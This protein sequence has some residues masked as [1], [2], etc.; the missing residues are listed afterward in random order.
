MKKSYEELYELY[1]KSKDP[2]E[3]S[4]IKQ[5]VDD[6]SLTETDE[7]FQS[8]PGHYTENFNDLIYQKKEFNANQLFLDTRG[9]E[10]A[11]GPDFSIKAHQSFLKNFMTK[12]SPYK[13]L[14]IYHG[15]GVGKTCSGLTI[16]ENF[17][18]TYARKDRRIL[19]LS[20]KNIQLGWKKTIYTPD[21]GE[22]QCTGDT[23][24]NSDATTDRGVNKL[25]KRYYE[26]MAYQSFSN[27][28]DKMIVQYTQRLP[29]D[30]K[31]MGEEQCIRE[32]FSNRLM[33]IDE[34]H[35]IRDE[36]GSTMR[37]TVKTIEKV[38]QY[39]DNLRLVLLTATPMYNRA[40]EILWILNMMLLND[41]R[42]II[43]NK[44]V[45]NSN[46]ELSEQ[47]SI[48]L[49]EKSRGYVSYLRGENPI[50]FPIR[51]Y[52]RQ[53]KDARRN[54]Y[55]PNYSKDKQNSIINR[56]FAPLVN[57]VGGKIKD[58]LQFLELFGSKLGGLQ[59]LVYKQAIKNLVDKDPLLDIDVR[60]EMNPILD[61]VSLTQITDMTYPSEKDNLVKK[62]ND[63]DINVDEFYGER[64]LKN[65]M[66]KRGSNYTY[67][68]KILDKYGPIFDKDN[69][70]DYSSKLSSIINIIDETEGIIFI[71]TNYVSAGIVPLQL[72]LEQNGYKKHSG[73]TSLQ[74]PGWSKSAAKGKTKREPISFDGLRRS[75]VDDRFQQASYM[76]I[77]ASTNK[78]T[79]Q[80]QLKIIN[81][82]ENKNGEKIKVIIGTV[83][84]SE[85][86]DFKRI[87]CVHILDPWHHL[88][89]TEQTIG[90]S[91]RFCSHS[92]LSDNKK[93]VLI[94]LHT[95]TLPDGMESIDT[96]IYRY[97]ERKSFQIGQVEMI[98]KRCAVD[99]YLYK[100]VNVIGKGTIQHIS[101]S[102]PLYNAIDVRVDP[103]DTSYSKVCSYSLDCDYNKGLK[104]EEDPLLNDDTFLD[105]YSSTS[106]SN[107][108][109]K[110]ALLF[111]EFYVYDINSILGLLN[112]YGFNQDT[113]I[114]QALDKMI[115]HKYVIHDKIGSSGYI[116]NS[117]KYYIFQPF[118]LEDQ[119]IPMYYR[120]NSITLPER[121]ITLPRLNEVDDTCNCSKT[122]PLD[123]I[124]EVY[125]SLWRHPDLVNV[126]E[127][128]NIVYETSSMNRV[129]V[130]Y[131]FDRLDFKDKCKLMYGYFRK[132]YEFKQYPIYDEVESLVD[133][134]IV[135][136]SKSKNDYYFNNEPID[137]K[138]TD[139]FGFVLSYN[140][141]PC[142]YEYYQGELIRC[143][144]VQLNQLGKSLDR[145]TKSPHYKQFMKS[146]PTWGY[147]IMRKKNYKQE[148]V[149]KFVHP[150]TKGAPE[151]T[152]YPPGPGNVCIEN[153]RASSIKDLKAVLE[154]DYGEVLQK[155]NDMQPEI[156][157]LNEMI[158]DVPMIS[159]M[160][161]N[162]LS[163]SEIRNRISDIER[164]M[165]RDNKKDMC[166]LLELV[167]RYSKKNS[168]YSYD[169]LWLKYR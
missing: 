117:N 110:I 166:V 95:A 1:D 107:L 161:S 12:E 14:L 74:Y 119:S 48:I 141:S 77:D 28:V 72:T 114:Y 33:I 23:F 152:K 145:Y 71:Y 129:V 91:I 101:L 162:S 168:F 41:K 47:G 164:I 30:E 116:I 26:L 123:S 167:L 134:M 64:G 34:V 58:K 43:N 24:V 18:D 137:K 147:T 11:C 16:G 158:V 92:D 120:M 31:H 135:Y 155:W 121:K 130:G 94:Y 146:T 126:V 54:Q 79:L 89:R 65:C 102:P 143:I 3:Q 80:D 39:S 150:K 85:G 62:L 20:S 86:L 67:K 132:D 29:E 66:N 103:S 142:F 118:L 32:Y 46:G 140:N 169:K 125:E 124:M 88:N 157:L 112:E 42:P 61:N 7:G 40:T 69:L 138:D 52:P 53:L 38:I 106:I 25:I 27:F 5:V 15:V 104:I 105:Q 51:L 73:G 108:K 97:A 115:I 83:V 76:I 139:I 98:L 17:R 35:N 49:Q 37:D 36:P 82:K 57:L 4:L 81:S 84:A 153:N 133:S 163:L 56:R 63:G 10:D 8:Y 90:R 45:F 55:F 165:P 154:T 151:T 111:K 2:K 128:L 22:N 6:K 75:E 136:K 21:K 44:D 144:Q 100:D 109:Q 122:Y 113:M 131:L 87:R 159:D 13:S 59:L 149:L 19:I 68:K 156:D 50:T 93:N 160:W 70:S 148:C 127:F 99:R 9:I 78:K 60:G 96:S